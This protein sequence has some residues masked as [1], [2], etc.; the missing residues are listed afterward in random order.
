MVVL[1]TSREG[2]KG[3]GKLADFPWVPAPTGRWVKSQTAVPSPSFITGP[4]SIVRH[5]TEYVD[6]SLW[7]V[8]TISFPSAD[9]CGW[10]DAFSQLTS[11]LAVAPAAERA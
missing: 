2:P 8:K 3:S 9:R 1:G 5:V 6:D 10:T 11:R 4:S 7:S